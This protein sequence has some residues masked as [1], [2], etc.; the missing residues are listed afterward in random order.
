MEPAGIIELFFGSVLMYAAT[1]AE[2]GPEMA[3]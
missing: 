1:V 3:S 2:S